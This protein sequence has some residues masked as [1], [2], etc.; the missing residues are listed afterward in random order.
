MAMSAGNRDD[1]FRLLACILVA[2]VLFVGGVSYAGDNAAADEDRNVLWDIVTNCLDP[3]RHDY[4]ATCRYQ[5][6]V[7]DAPCLDSIEVWARTDDLVAIRDRKMC[8]CP[9]G[10]VHGL[11]VP[12]QEVTGV[13]DERH[14]AGIWAFAWEVAKK[15]LPDDDIALVANPPTCRSQDQLHVH[16]VR[17]ND[18]GHK[19]G[20]DS[21]VTRIDD[22]REVWR[23]AEELAEK[24]RL[25]CYGILV[26]RVDKGFLVFVD[27]GCLEK[28]YTEYR[29]GR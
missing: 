14:P 4:S 25:D 9:D 20:E 24:A 23:K 17:L 8:G 16:M 18:N 21:L 1:P 2:A 5:I 12:I 29:C 3:G 6:D 26:K 28:T 27:D 10:F 7:K 22:L 13:E 19:L 11:A 15:R